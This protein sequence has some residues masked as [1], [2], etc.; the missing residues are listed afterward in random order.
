MTL[1]GSGSGFIVNHVPGQKKT[2]ENESRFC[3]F[4]FVQSGAV[5]VDGNL[6][7]YLELE[8]KITASEALNPVQMLEIKSQRWHQLLHELEAAQKQ[9]DLLEKIV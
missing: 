3:S 7:K 5:Y 8:R 2:K 6:Q 4:F 9:L 1:H